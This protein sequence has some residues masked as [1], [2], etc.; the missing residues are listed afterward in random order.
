MSNGDVV[1]GFSPDMG[2]IQGLI[3]GYFATVASMAAIGAG[4]VIF[5]DCMLAVGKQVCLPSSSSMH[6]SIHSSDL[7]AGRACTCLDTLMHAGELKT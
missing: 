6:G 5:K 2:G 1:H 4:F 7:V 3:N